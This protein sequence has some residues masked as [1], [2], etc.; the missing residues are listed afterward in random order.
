MTS[1]VIL[2]ARVHVLPEELDNNISDTLFASLQ[3]RKQEFNSR[4]NGSVIEILKVLEYTNQVPSSGIVV[5]LV[6]FS[7]TAFLPEKGKEL[8]ATV[9][10]VISVGIVCCFFGVRIWIHGEEL[11]GYH[12][13]DN[14]FCGSNGR[15][16]VGDTMRVQ[17]STIRYEK[18][19]FSC[20]GSLVP[21]PGVLQLKE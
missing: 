20:I 16:C 9:E 11:L 21:E 8:D 18:K 1:E 5:F 14:T 19:I 13:D 15:V 4:E 12:W 2:V 6:T 3:E 7:A 17:I 10:R